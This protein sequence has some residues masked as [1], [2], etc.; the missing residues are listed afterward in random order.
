MNFSALVYELFPNSLSPSVALF[1]QPK[2]PTEQGKIVYATP[3]PSSVS[4][5]LGV[6]A[7]DSTDIRYLEREELRSHP[8]LWKVALWGNPRDAGVIERLQALPTLDQQ[9]ERLGWNKI[10][11][12]FISA[13]IGSD[14][15]SCSLALWKTSCGCK[16]KKV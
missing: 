14:E 11:E 9:R 7:L 2:Q 13:Y 15:E 8:A 3:K 4:K 12:G 1:Y 6:M 16:E 5:S 10:E